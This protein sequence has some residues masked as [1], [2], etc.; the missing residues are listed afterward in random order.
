M[1]ATSQMR[2]S[3]NRIFTATSGQWDRILNIPPKAMRPVQ[4]SNSRGFVTVVS[5]NSICQVKATTTIGVETFDEVKVCGPGEPAY[6]AVDE[7]A[8][9]ISYKAVYLTPYVHDE[10]G[11][12]NSTA[13]SSYA[14]KAGYRPD[15]EP[16]VRQERNVIARATFLGTEFSGTI[17][18]KK[19]PLGPPGLWRIE[20]G[21]WIRS[22]DGAAP[23]ATTLS[24]ISVSATD[25][26]TGQAIDLIDYNS[27]SRGASLSQHAPS[28]TVTTYGSRE[29]GR[30][31]HSYNGWGSMRMVLDAAP[32]ADEVYTVQAVWK[33]GGLG[34]YAQWENSS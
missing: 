18:L 17:L 24:V 31:V 32:T 26:Y 20:R 13:A 27:A 34:N 19:M 2:Y 28:P 12:P 5:E 22:N 29:G 4:I 7:F 23:Q 9:D 33:Y 8:L 10:Y 3:V 21:S 1:T 25:V 15:G 6:F 14:I 11:I 30:Y 16:P